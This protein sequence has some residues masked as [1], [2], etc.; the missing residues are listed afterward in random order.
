MKT[1]FRNAA[2]NL[3]SEKRK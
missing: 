3:K 2:T 1:K